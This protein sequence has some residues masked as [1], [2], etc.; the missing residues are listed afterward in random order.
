MFNTEE[1]VSSDSTFLLRE[2][3][4]SEN[5]ICIDWSFIIFQLHQFS[6]FFGKI[7]GIASWVNR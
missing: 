3:I 1:N 2:V 7:A 5:E 6:I 4:C